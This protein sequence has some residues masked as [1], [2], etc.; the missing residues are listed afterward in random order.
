MPM[1]LG[2]ACLHAFIVR[3]VEDLFPP[4]ESPNNSK[5][6]SWSHSASYSEHFTQSLVPGSIQ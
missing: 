4:A 3:Y 6:S 5:S 2:R 1:V